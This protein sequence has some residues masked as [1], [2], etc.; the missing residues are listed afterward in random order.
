MP[1]HHLTEAFVKAKRWMS[2]VTTFVAH[3]PEDTEKAAGVS[4]DKP[5]KPLRTR[6]LHKL[7]PHNLW[8]MPG[9]VVCINCRRAANTRKTA[10]SL[11]SSACHAFAARGVGEGPSQGP[12]EIAQDLFQVELEER[13][14]KPCFVES[15]ATREAERS[16][17]PTSPT[18]ES[19]KRRRLYKKASPPETATGSLAEVLATKLLGPNWRNSV[20]DTHV[21]AATVGRVFCLKCARFSESAGRIWLLGKACRSDASNR[22]WVMRQFK[23]LKAGKSP[24][25][26]NSQHRVYAI[27]V[28]ERGSDYL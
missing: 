21:R 7:R 26:V 23:R 14:G 20:H 11:K 19:H 9:K 22:P 1:N 12:R 2:W 6:Q 16:Q 17:G 5:K 27:D 4:V 28:K 24:Y 15:A 3:W 18:V 13:G 8:Q 10:L 25:S